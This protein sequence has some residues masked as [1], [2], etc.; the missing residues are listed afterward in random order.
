[1]HLWWWEKPPIQPELMG[2]SCYYWQAVSYR[3]S[4]LQIV[5]VKQNH[6]PVQETYTSKRSS[7]AMQKSN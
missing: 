2:I 3:S 6:K 5:S 4:Y 1:M 7:R